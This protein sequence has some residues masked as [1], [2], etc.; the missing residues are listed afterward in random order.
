ML[1]K[2]SLLFLL[3]RWKFP[4]L[5]LQFVSGYRIHNLRIRTIIS[6]MCSWKGTEAQ[7]SRKYNEL[8]LSLG[9]E[10]TYC[11]KYMRFQFTYVLVNA[12]VKVWTK[13]YICC[14]FSCS[15]SLPPVAYNKQIVYYWKF[16]T[17][18]FMIDSLYFVGTQ[19]SQHI[20]YLSFFLFWK[21]TCFINHDLSCIPVF[22]FLIY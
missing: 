21:A 11:Q 12:Y 14:T 18:I 8:Y 9:I 17:F 13:T 7:N 2:H 20:M 1:F 22:S 6:T 15:S 5:L 16:G 19:N 4:F 10:R 3:L